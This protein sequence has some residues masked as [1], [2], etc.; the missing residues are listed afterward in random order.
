MADSRPLI[1]K[2]QVEHS[3]GAKGSRTSTN[4][5]TKN[6]KVNKAI[7]SSSEENTQETKKGNLFLDKLHKVG[8]F[9]L[10]RFLGINL[11]L[12][13]LVKQSAVYTSVLGALF[14]MLGAL[15]DMILAPLLP[16][17]IPFLR[18]FAQNLP[19]I[20][21]KITS[22][23]EWLGG[24]FV[25]FYNFS[26][27]VWPFMEKIWN[28]LGGTLKYWVVGL[29]LTR[30]VGFHATFIAW[31]A[32]LLAMIA[33]NFG[34]LLAFLAKNSIGRMLPRLFGRGKD[35]KVAGPPM[36]IATKVAY[37]NALAMGAG[38]KG[39][40]GG[41]GPVLG[42][43]TRQAGS[44][45]ALMGTLSSPWVLA[46]IV[47]VGVA[48][49]GIMAMKAHHNAMAD[50]QLRRYDSVIANVEHVDEN[51]NQISDRQARRNIAAQNKAENA[52]LID[53]NAA[54]VRGISF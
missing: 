45:A 11:A 26:I 28:F 16:M 9:Q 46:A 21:S 5:E 54:G 20:A 8:K 43:T 50:R 27:R 48:A 17:L 34:K 12:H 32:Q 15:I 14:Q 31:S 38:G 47:A 25:D 36:T 22:V 2:I 4:G 35:G 19:G 23:L 24:K 29:I 40:P 30:M 1:A 52:T 53:A 44:R 49:A 10:L 13:T 42:N 18:S 33:L 39:P 51:G 7:H 6:D 41:I 37:I 3:G